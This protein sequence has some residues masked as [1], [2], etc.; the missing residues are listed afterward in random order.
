[1]K[2]QI[3]LSGVVFKTK[4]N[5]KLEAHGGCYLKFRGGRCHLAVTS[6]VSIGE[7]IRD[8][9]VRKRCGSHASSNYIKTPRTYLIF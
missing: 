2:Y 6:C 4:G 8:T 1:M 5:L 7:M 3:C 9:A